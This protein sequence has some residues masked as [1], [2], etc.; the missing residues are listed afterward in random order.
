MRLHVYGVTLAQQC[1]QLVDDQP[2]EMPSGLGLPVARQQYRSFEPLRAR[3]VGDISLS[4]GT[5]L[6]VA[7]VARLD[8]GVRHQTGQ[9]DLRCAVAV[10]ISLQLLDQRFRALARNVMVQRYIR[11]EDLFGF[12]IGGNRM[13]YAA[14]EISRE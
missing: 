6:T 9:G 10:Q 1:K 2:A 12:G 13:C 5:W 11:D 7:R 8:E 4:S 14:G 3:R